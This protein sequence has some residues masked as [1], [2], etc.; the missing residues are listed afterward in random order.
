MRN[1]IIK[2]FIESKEKS[3]MS[4]FETGAFPIVAQVLTGTKAMSGRTLFV[5][6][7]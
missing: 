4:H 2:N 6:V 5:S 1:V 3:S 7:T